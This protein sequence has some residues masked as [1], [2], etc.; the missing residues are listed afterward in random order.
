[1]SDNSLVSKTRIALSQLSESALHDL[2]TYL[3]ARRAAQQA[4][5]DAEARRLATGET[6]LTSLLTTYNA[7]EI[8][9]ALDAKPWETEHPLLTA[10]INAQEQALGAQQQVSR[11]IT[12]ELE[13][14][15][16]AVYRLV[17]EE[18]LRY[19]NGVTFS[20]S[21]L[22]VK[23]TYNLVRD[24]SV[25][26]F[27]DL[28]GRIIGHQ[29]YKEI[30]T[31]KMDDVGEDLA[32]YS[33]QKSNICPRIIVTDIYLH[34]F[35]RQGKKRYVMDLCFG[36]PTERNHVKFQSLALPDA[37]REIEAK[38]PLAYF[39]RPEE[40]NPKKKYMTFLD[41]IGYIRR[42]PEVIISDYQRQEQKAIAQLH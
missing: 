28:L 37:V 17:L 33:D 23:V 42:I 14:I 15:V 6:A 13:S 8:Q 12:K 9:H 5:K 10:L 27:R 21:M 19:E 35:V 34:L 31:I 18:P 32:G 20:A 25:T 7:A 3:A 40:D 30:L 38:I 22:R 41:V 26:S 39:Y 1:M 16:D 24:T 29:R 36:F 11:Q 2:E 4:E